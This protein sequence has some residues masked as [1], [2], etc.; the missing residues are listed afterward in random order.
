LAADPKPPARI[1]DPEL[2][3]QLH[4]EWTECFLCFRA[5]GRLSL[6]HIHKHPRDDLRENL[7]ML[8]GDGV[9]GCHGQVELRDPSSCA[10]LGL[11]LVKERP[12]VVR[13][14]SER[15]GGTEQASAWLERYLYV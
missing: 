14:L 8:C 11:Y 3:K 13:Y 15:L 5:T 12:D 7:V 2:M 4:L 10:L 6:H 1:R 9:R